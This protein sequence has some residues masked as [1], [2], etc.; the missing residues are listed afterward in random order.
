MS[1][2][3]KKKILI[4]L[5]SENVLSQLVSTQITAQKQR[6]QQQIYFQPVILEEGILDIR[7]ISEKLYLIVL[8]KG[9]NKEGKLW[10]PDW[11]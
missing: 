5:I 11:K 4:R 1:Q 9:F 7:V 2:R 8:M 10:S 6:E 3:T